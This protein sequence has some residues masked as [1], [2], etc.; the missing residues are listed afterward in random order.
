MC[1]LASRVRVR[2]RVRVRVR[3]AVYRADSDC[4]GVSD[5]ER[6]CRVLP[7]TTNAS[8]PAGFA[9]CAVFD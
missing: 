7:L 8:L 5:C 9:R 2:L 1:C 6:L 4:A 3:C